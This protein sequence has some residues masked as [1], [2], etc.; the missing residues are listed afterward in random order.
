[1][2]SYL[3][4]VRRGR[5]IPLRKL[6]ALLGCSTQNLFCRLYTSGPGRGPNLGTLTKLASA[7]GVAIIL[8]PVDARGKTDPRLVIPPPAPPKTKGDPP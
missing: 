2:V 6:A 5:G 1:M 7:L 8:V 4:R 3:N